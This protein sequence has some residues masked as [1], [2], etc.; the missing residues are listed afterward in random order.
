MDPV[1]KVLNTPVT[2][3]FTVNG[4]PVEYSFHELTI[5]EAAVYRSRLQAKAV[6]DWQKRLKLVAATIE[7]ERE[8][9]KYRME[10]ASAEPN[11][12]P[13]LARLSSTEEG[14]KWALQVGAVPSLSDV[15]F[16]AINDNGD[17]AD[18]LVQAI[19]TTFGIKPEKKAEA[20]A[21]ANPPVSQPPNQ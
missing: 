13:E 11:W 16:A 5:G 6:S 2:I 1:S 8:R 18:A 15:A 20:S 3:I 7:S 19:N 12:E 10:A 14:I 21:E 9:T 4:A 17:N